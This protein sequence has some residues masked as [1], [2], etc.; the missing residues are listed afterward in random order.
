[1]TKCI[2]ARYIARQELYK[3]LT[4]KMPSSRQSKTTAILKNQRSSRENE[5]DHRDEPKWRHVVRRCYVT[6]V[7]ATTDDASAHV[8]VVKPN[9]VDEAAV[10]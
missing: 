1:M 10:V 9:S 3:H 8:T 7:R 5:T 2:K 4:H 6:A